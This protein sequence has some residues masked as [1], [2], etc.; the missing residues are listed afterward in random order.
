MLSC[1]T[2]MVTLVKMEKS[3]LGLTL[4]GCAVMELTLLVHPG[5]RLN[6]VSCYALGVTQ[7]A[8]ATSQIT[9]KGQFA[10]AW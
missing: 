1:T 8:Q 6:H 7:T 3:Q 2:L 9:T 10:K 4:V 5:I